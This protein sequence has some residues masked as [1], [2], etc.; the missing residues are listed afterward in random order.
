M[1]ALSCT[2]L[3]AAN[4]IHCLRVQ[5]LTWYIQIGYLY[6]I[7]SCREGA[8]RRMTRKASFL[9]ATILRVMILILPTSSLFKYK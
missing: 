5:G 2:L 7:L 1:F 3:Y 8:Q 6:H 9:T 4:F